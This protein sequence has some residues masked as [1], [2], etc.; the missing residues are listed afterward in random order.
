[1]RAREIVEGASFPPHVMKVVRDA[2]DGAWSAVE[3]QFRG[4]SSGELEQARL[5]MAKA[6][7]A[8]T[9]QDSTN[10]EVLKVEALKRFGQPPAT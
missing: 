8:A 9:T 10:V 5:A 6:V 7:L 1:M 2:F 4:V 3:D